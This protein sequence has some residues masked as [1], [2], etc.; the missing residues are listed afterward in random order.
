MASLENFIAHVDMPPEVREA[1]L[2]LQKFY[3]VRK[4]TPAYAE[5]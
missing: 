4:A 2:Y 5:P 1:F 3:G